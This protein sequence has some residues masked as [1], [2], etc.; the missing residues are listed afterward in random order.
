[1]IDADF[2]ING[3]GIR[4]AID[5]LAAG[6]A[7]E[8]PNLSPSL[9]DRGIGPEAAL[10]LLSTYV[11]GGSARLGEALSGAHMDPPTPWVSWAA[12]LWNAALNQNMLHPATSPV[13][14]QIEEHVIGW[15]APEFGMEG[16]HMTPGSTVSNL[17][18][19]WVARE[20]AGVDEVVT[21]DVAHISIAKA[22]HLLGLSLTTIKSLPNGRM[23]LNSLPHDLGRAALVLTAGSTTLGSIDP[24][25][26]C[27]RAAWTHVDAAWAA[28][29]RFS[30]RYSSR[31]D[32]IERADSISISAHKLLFQPKESALVLF[33]ELALSNEAISFGG[34][35]LAAPNVGLLGS[36]A[37]VAVPLLATLVSWG[38]QGLAERIERC[39]ATA[40]QLA[41][42]LEKVAGIEIACQ[43]ASGILLWRP[44][45]PH[46]IPP[47]EQSVPPHVA[48]QAWFHGAKWFRNVIANPNADPVALANFIEAQLLSLSDF[49]AGTFAA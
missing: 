24:F 16:G 19:L 25:D 44:R 17:T 13:A 2:L 33:R 35:Y 46:L 40:E 23:D 45:E 28:P 1:M 20:R 8:R 14:G 7:F 5:R 38:R 36:R 3:P 18:A 12:T 34:P 26:V 30:G 10:E 48:S 43:P 29:L 4:R 22:A 39:M 31:L 15:I 9:P 42:L 21:S 49:P 47:L 37:A 41:N 27:G 32:G 11:L 6:A